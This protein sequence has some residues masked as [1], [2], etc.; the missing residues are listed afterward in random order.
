MFNI[1][2]RSP[3]AARDQRD[4]G[5]KGTNM[6]D[7][8]V[9]ERI[10]KEINSQDVMVFMFFRTEVNCRMPKFRINKIGIKFMGINNIKT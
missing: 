6:S 2:N 3:K 10:K 7:T 8:P 4:T 5:V 1:F 9:N